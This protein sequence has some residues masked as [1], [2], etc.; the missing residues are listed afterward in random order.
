MLGMLD[1]VLA[2][3]AIVQYGLFGGNT[4]QETNQMFFIFSQDLL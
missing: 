2:S 1:G 4:L 3:Q